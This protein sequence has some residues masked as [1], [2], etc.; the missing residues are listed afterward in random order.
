MHRTL[1]V[2]CSDRTY[3]H[4][5]KLF[6]TNPTFKEFQ[7]HGV[8]VNISW[9]F[10]FSSSVLLKN[11]DNPEIFKKMPDL[12]NFAYDCHYIDK[13]DDILNSLK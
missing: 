11:L 6:N 10:K 7:D 1:S 3:L 4:L 9:F 8:K 5:Q 12:N 2:K 13:F